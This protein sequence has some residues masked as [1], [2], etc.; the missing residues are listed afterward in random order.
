MGGFIQEGGRSAPPSNARWYLTL[1]LSADLLDEAYY[2]L[3]A[4]APSWVGL[5]EGDVSREY[6]P[7][8]GS[9]AT[10][11]LVTK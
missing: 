4:Y 5:F 2:R 10:P 8:R 9:H 11:S 1:G 7:T 3:R 6:V